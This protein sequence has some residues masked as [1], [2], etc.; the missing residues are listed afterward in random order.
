META[1]HPISADLK[2]QGDP[3]VPAK[4]VSVDKNGYQ[5]VGEGIPGNAP[6]VLVE[7]RVRRLI[8]LLLTAL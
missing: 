1:D 2:P 4:T 7:L 5:S 8:G 6:A 3:S